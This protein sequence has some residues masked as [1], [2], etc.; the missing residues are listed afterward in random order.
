M[1]EPGTVKKKKTKHKPHIL[2]EQHV[3]KDQIVMKEQGSGCVVTCGV[4]LIGP[5]TSDGTVTGE[6]YL[7]MLDTEVL[8]NI[9]NP[10]GM[11]P[12]WFQQDGA[13][14]HHMGVRKSPREGLDSLARF[15]LRMDIE[16]GRWLSLSWH[17]VEAGRVT[18]GW[19]CSVRSWLNWGRHPCNGS[20][21]DL[22][23][24]HLSCTEMESNQAGNIC[25]SSSCMVKTAFDA[26]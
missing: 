14:F 26:N 11:L 7:H 24:D 6:R 5:S 8:Q 19:E 2:D 21:L 10:E 25:D 13:Q 17:V 15:F 20:N 23:S 4:R 18:C 9:L 12:T 22:K 16:A 1:T 3:S